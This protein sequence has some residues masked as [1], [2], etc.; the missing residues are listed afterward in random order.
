MAIKNI[1]P[2]HEGA[3]VT[4]YNVIEA[5]GII[6][7]RIV[8]PSGEDHYIGHD[9]HDLYIVWR[10]KDGHKNVQCIE[11]P[12]MEIYYVKDKYRT[13]LT[14]REYIEIEKVHPVTITYEPWEVIKNIVRNMKESKDIVAQSILK[15]I[16]EAKATGNYSLKKQAHKWPYVLMSD[17]DLETY[18]WI[19]LGYNYNTMHGHVID[20]CFADIEN[21]IYGMSTAETRQNLDPVNACTLIFEYDEN[22]PNKGKGTQVY[23]FLLRDHKRYPQQ[24]EFEENLGKF[25]Q[26]CHDSFDHQTVMKKGKEKIID[27]YADYHI[28]LFNTEKELLE[29]IFERINLEKPDLCEFWNMPYDMPKMKARME[30]LGMN[31][32]HVMSDDDYFQFDKQFC[33]FHI[34]NRPIDIANRNSYIRLTS[35]TQYVDQMQH[36]AGIRKG[37]K[38]YGSN[39]LDN[40]ANIELGMGKWDFADGIDVTNAAILDY[41]NFVLY[42]IRDVW[43]QVLIDQVTN[44]S[45]ALVYD[46]NQMNCPLYHLAKQTKYQRYI[47]Y[48]W[49]LRK[50]FVPGNNVNVNYRRYASEDAMLSEEDAK[51]KQAQRRAI[52]LLQT[53]DGME[54]D[55]D[56]MDSAAEEMEDDDVKSLADVINENVSYALA[57][58]VD[59][60]SDSINRKVLL[61]GGC[62]G[63][64]DYNIANGME[65]IPGIKSKHFFSNVIDMDF[66]SEYPWAKFTRSLSRST[67]YGRLIIPHKVSEWQN[68]LP[69]GKEKRAEDTRRYLPGGEFV[70]D[71]LSQDIL[72][73]GTVWFSLPFVE[74]CDKMITKMLEKEED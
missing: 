40:I 38:A 4:L 62:V 74:D 27:T 5:R 44:D 56:D 70:S 7:E 55:P 17:L 20:K 1:L 9:Y 6:T 46:M 43:C 47:Y 11:W 3:D 63:D 32:E 42:N 61:Q 15:D 41:W 29:K 12:K 72:S 33:R 67:Q 73:F 35:T 69:L 60:F 22:G 53:N 28:E 37:R 68:K 65:L 18:Y 50:G 64:P 13:F 66:S 30:I 26:T 14:P 10:D 71:Y 24:K 2:V 52:D 59:I 16:D 57:D 45:M 48:T 19:Q 39:S 23:T 54:I 25:Y 58:Q 21:D 36:Y 34:D 31:P 49:Y 8:Y 51:A